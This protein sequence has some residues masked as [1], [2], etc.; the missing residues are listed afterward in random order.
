MIMKQWIKFSQDQ[1]FVQ[2]TFFLEIVTRFKIA[3]TIIEGKYD[4]QVSRKQL[5][6]QREGPYGKP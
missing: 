3:V 6:K 4:I 1:T 5:C 2:A